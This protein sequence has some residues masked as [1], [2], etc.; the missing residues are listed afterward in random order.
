MI[1]PTLVPVLCTLLLSSSACD[2][3]P[4]AG[5]AEHT[6]EVPSPLGED[7]APPE[8][9]EPPEPLDPSVVEAGVGAEP[10]VADDGVVRVTWSRGDVDVDVDGA[11]FPSSAGLTSWAGFAP[12]GDGVMVMGDTVVFE[13]EVDAAMDAAFAHDLEITAL[14]NHFFFDD[15][16]VYFMH[17][18]GNGGTEALARGVGAVWEAIRDVRRQRPEPA[19]S[20]GGRPPTRAGDLDATALEDILGT[21][22]A[23]KDAGVLKASFP[24]EARM[25]RTPI[26]GTMGLASWAAFRG[27]DAHATVDG[28]FA[29]RSEEVQPVLRALRSA[30]IHVVALHNHM[31]N[32]EPSYYFT[33]FWAVGPAPE[34]ARG[35][36]TALD[37]LGER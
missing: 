13:D 8:D 20:F 29:M 31:I 2:D 24:R 27:S 12:R 25:R 36:R 3:P 18:G 34:L 28:D 17:V 11:P 10:T 16:S 35:V 7:P 1:R 15:P 19:S 14:H 23:R 22:L 6:D 37:T 5:S 9:P 33:H 30:D 32:E 4:G 21:E 26:G